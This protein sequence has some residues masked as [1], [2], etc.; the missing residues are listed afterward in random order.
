MNDNAVCFL[1]T[2]LGIEIL[3]YSQNDVVLIAK[4]FEEYLNGNKNY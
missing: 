2:N 3:R 4:L 1:L